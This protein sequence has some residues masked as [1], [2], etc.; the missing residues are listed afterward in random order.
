M[1]KETEIVARLAGPEIQP[2]FEFLIDLGCIFSFRRFRRFRTG[3]LNLDPVIQ[4]YKHNKFA[5]R[6]Y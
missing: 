6:M 5:Y 3:K 1:Q 4:W 2:G